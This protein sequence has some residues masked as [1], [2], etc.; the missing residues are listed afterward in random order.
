MRRVQPEGDFVSLADYLADPANHRPRSGGDA[1]AAS[2]TRDGADQAAGTSDDEAPSVF[3]DVTGAV[4][5][6]SSR[7]G[8]CIGRAG[9]AAGLTDRRREALLG[10][11]NDGT[12]GEGHTVC[13]S[14]LPGNAYDLP[15]SVCAWIAEHPKAAPRSHAIRMAASFGIQYVDP[16]AD[17]PPKD[18]APRTAG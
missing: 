4:R 15:P 6:M 8:T 7:C 5:V 12:Y 9:N 11:R 14:T 1:A 18:P 13:H 16:S 17:G 2:R 10:R 3:D